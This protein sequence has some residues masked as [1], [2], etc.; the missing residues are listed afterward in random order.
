MVRNPIVVKLHFFSEKLHAHEREDEDYQDEQQPLQCE[1]TV[2]VQLQTS[3]VFLKSSAGG[4][5]HLNHF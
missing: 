2:K 1:D 4:V 3:R 5:Q